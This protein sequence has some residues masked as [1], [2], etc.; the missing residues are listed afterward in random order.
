MKVGDLVRFSYFIEVD[1]IGVIV[2]LSDDGHYT[3]YWSDGDTD[4]DLIY[5]ELELI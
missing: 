1:A 5:S 3:V 2:A 4:T